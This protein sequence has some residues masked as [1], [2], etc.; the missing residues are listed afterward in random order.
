MRPPFALASFLL[1]VI[2]AGCG[3]DRPASALDSIA[4]DSSLRRPT[5]FSRLWAD[6]SSA[7]RVDTMIYHAPPRGA[8]K[9]ESIAALPHWIVGALVSGGCAVPQM[10][11]SERP[12]NFMHG[13]FRAKGDSVWVVACVANG[14]AG[15]LVFRADT[16][17]APDSL[18]WGTVEAEANRYLRDSTEKGWTWTREISTIDPD[19]AR[20]WCRAGAHEP[21][22]LGITE[23]SYQMQVGAHYF[24][25]GKWHGCPDWP[26]GD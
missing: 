8:L 16:T 21:I 22:H 14:R 11:G 24:E 2:L 12:G 7:H 1:S 15:I 13:E 23:F 19:E 17:L 9:P 26:E 25:D 20:K 6:S 3:N 18:D 10:V 4:A 5:D